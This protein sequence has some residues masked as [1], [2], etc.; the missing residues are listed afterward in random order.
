MTDDIGTGDVMQ[1]VKGFGGGRHGLGF[2]G[3][4]MVVTKVSDDYIDGIV[5]SRGAIWPIKDW[6][7]ATPDLVKKIGRTVL[8]VD[9]LKEY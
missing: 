3:C 4:F 7:R 6:Y 9:E 2:V 8:T 5:I 1:I